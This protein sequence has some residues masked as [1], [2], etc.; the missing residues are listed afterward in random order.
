M[1]HHSGARIALAAALVLA[2]ALVPT[3][4]AGKPGG[5]GTTSN[6]TISLVLLESTDGLAHYGQ[7]VTFDVSTT[8][9]TSP[10]V[11]LRCYQ[12]GAL[13]GQGWE[14]FFEASIDDQIMVLG[15]SQAWQGGD[16]DCTAT[17]NKRT[18]RGW[19][20]LATTSFHVYA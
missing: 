2:L 5:G 6:G 9:T 11:N 16:A 20:Q 8:A 12:N 18:K 15:G 1:I 7:R 19:Q 3:G 4:L 14:G 13:V 17:L 10:Y